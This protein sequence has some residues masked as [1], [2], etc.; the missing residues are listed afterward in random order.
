M[1]EPVLP[2]TLEP[3]VSQVID[4]A[5]RTLPLGAMFEVRIYGR[6]GAFYVGPTIATA[7][8]QS[9]PP[10]R[11]LLVTHAQPVPQ[12]DHWLVARLHSNGTGGVK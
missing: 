7:E 3:A 12:E 11:R 10:L 9:R 6:P 1:S 2:N 4:E 8:I 5:H